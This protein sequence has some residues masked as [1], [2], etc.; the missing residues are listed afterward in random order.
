M[1]L[2]GLERSAFVTGEWLVK[3]EVRAFKSLFVGDIA[4]KMGNRSDEAMKP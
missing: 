4:A 3:M 1:S 2:K